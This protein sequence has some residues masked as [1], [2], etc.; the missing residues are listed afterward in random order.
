MLVEKRLDPL[1]YVKWNS[2]A[3]FVHGQGQDGGEHAGVYSDVP[4]AGQDDAELG[5]IV[6]S[7]EEACSD[8]EGSE[9]SGLTRGIASI[10][11]ANIPPEWVPQTF[12]HFSYESTRGRMMVCDLQGVLTPAARAG[13]PPTFELTDPVRSHDPMPQPRMPQC[14]L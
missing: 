7:D 1:R 11:I 4:S 6:E 9:L 3:G 10:S 13:Q 12:T 5:V 2:N 8:S 14:V